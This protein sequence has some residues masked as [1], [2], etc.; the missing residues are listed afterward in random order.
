MEDKRADIVLPHE[1]AREAVRRKKLLRFLKS[2]LSAW[3][4]ADHP[5]LACGAARWV[6]ELRRDSESKRA[7]E[8]RRTKV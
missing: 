7:G 4:D 8:P 6:R 2:G 1:T 5:E 3:K